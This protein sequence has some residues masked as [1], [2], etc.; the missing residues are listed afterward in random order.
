MLEIKEVSKF[1]KDKVALERVSI[2]LAPGRVCGLLGLNGAGKSTLMKII[3][4]LTIPSEG[5]VF[6]DEEDITGKGSGKIG[7]MIENPV[8]YNELTGA[9]NLSVLGTLFGNIGPIEIKE[10]IKTVGLEKSANIRYGKYSLGMKQR[11]YFAYALLNHPKVL[12]LD[13][14]FNGVDPV[15]VRLFEQIIKKLAAESCT[16]LISGHIIAELEK[17]CDSVIII[18]EG[19]VKYVCEDLSTVMSLEELFIDKVAGAGDAQ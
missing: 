1:Y 8:F 10:V 18:D 2:A 17:I 11:L 19:A 4:G 6:L 16:V 7:C 12:I 15:S 3:C 13:E 9:E 5:K 14:P